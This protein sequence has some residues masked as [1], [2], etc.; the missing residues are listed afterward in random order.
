MK[1]ENEGSVSVKIN[2]WNQKFLLY[3]AIF[4]ILFLFCFSRPFH[5][6]QDHVFFLQT[7]DYMADFFNVAKYCA[8]NNPYF[9]GTDNTLPMETYY[10]AETGSAEQAYFPLTYVIMHYMSTLADY[11]NGDAFEV[12][13]SSMGLVTS[14][15]F[16]CFMCLLYFGLVGSFQKNKVYGYLTT[17]VLFFSGINICSFERGNIIYLSA[18]GCLLF[19]KFY[20]SDREILRQTAYVSLAV[21]AALKG[22]PALLGIVLLYE[23]RYKDAAILMLYGVAM[24]FL[25]FLLVENGFRN[26]PRWYV[27]LKA[28]N[29]AYLFGAFPRFGY[30][31]FLTHIPVF[32]NKLEILHKI[33]QVC[34]WLMAIIT[35]LTA[36][37]QKVNW[38][39][40]GA[41]LFLIVY[42]PT[43]SGFYMGLY[44]LP[45]IVMFFAETLHE[46]WEIIFIPL[47]IVLICPF[48][49]VI[50]NYN[51]TQMF[52]N[53]SA[54]I[55]FLLLMLCNIKSFYNC[56]FRKVQDE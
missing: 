19:L 49:V 20:N 44:L 16:M 55:I 45:I 29:A 3:S 33:C 42:L 1:K 8:E 54:M 38:M 22:Y 53:A 43:N 48:Q 7:G 15:L 9:Y 46:K 34:V 11:R 35:F 37:Y 23:K 5:G 2:E 12:G 25:P 28:N 26:I 24:I 56:K 41:L 14:T 50:G 47:F 32:W 13:M 40:W 10:A 36:K 31:H 6:N 30:L 39:K 52:I 17:I 21:A 18:I 4:I 51:Y 27:N